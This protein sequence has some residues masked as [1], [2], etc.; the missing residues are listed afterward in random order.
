[1]SQYGWGTNSG[2][3]WLKRR[4]RTNKKDM[5]DV[6]IQLA[7]DPTADISSV[8]GTIRAPNVNQEKEIRDFIHFAQIMN[9][10]QKKT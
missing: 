5:N 7:H 6:L 1:M 3:D 10:L 8:V 4:C 9:L 2:L